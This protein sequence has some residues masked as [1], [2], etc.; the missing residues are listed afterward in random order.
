MLRMLQ[1]QLERIL[2]H[3]VDVEIN[4]EAIDLIYEL[5]D[6][7]DSLEE[8]LEDLKQDLE[9]NYRPIPVSE[10]VGISDRDFL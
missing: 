4:D 5:I 9:E 1:V 8:E 3:E 2:K 6:A 7:Y 10:Q